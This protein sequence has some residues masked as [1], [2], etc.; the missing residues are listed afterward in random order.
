MK[1]TRLVLVV[2]L[3]L[4][5]P[6]LTQTAEARSKKPGNDII[7]GGNAS[8]GEYPFMVA[9]LDASLGD[10]AFDQQICGGTL[11]DP[12]WVLTAAHCILGDED[13]FVA[14]NRTK[15]TPGAS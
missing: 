12:E 7:E 8:P 6:G 3:A 13:L 4:V 10:S 2:L 5:L 1:R 14:V 9:V 15:S 11:I